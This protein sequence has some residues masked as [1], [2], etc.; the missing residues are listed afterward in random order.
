MATLRAERA[1]VG[2]SLRLRWVLA[3]VVGFTAGGA[4][5]GTIAGALVQQ[6][7]PGVVT[8]ASEAV[9]VLTRAAGAATA[10]FGMVVGTTQWLAIR[11]DVKHVGWW[12]PATTLG[13][14]LA[15]VVAGLSG[16]MGGAVTG[17]GPDLGLWGYLVSI[18]V[19]FLAVGLLPVVF[20]MLVLRGRVGGAGRWVLGAGGAF[21]LAAVVAFA[22]V[23]WGLVDVI[24]WLRLEDFPSAKPFVL[25]GVLVGLLYGAVTGALLVRLLGRSLSEP[26]EREKS[27]G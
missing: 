21:F 8:S 17:V 10:V 7:S 23:R 9:P 26:A 25:F 11:E 5:A 16:I 14:A 24:G 3:N 18:A 20:Q 13:W 4:I 12:I 27:G 22:V 6:Y 2:W 15:G 1:W 19:G